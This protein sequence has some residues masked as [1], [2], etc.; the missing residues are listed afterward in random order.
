[1]RAGWLRC[2]RPCG[3]FGDLSTLQPSY[4][5]VIGRLATPFVC[6]AN[7]TTAEPPWR[8]VNRMWSSQ[9]LWDVVINH[10]EQAAI[11][12]TGGLWCSQRRNITCA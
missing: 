1:M 3:R 12:I 5:A 10:A 9:T 4:T 11:T 7:R 6:S 2:L 8:F